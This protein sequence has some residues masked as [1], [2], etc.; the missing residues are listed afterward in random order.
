LDFFDFEP[1]K[2]RPKNFR[3]KKDPAVPTFEPEIFA[4]KKFQTVR[5]A[6]DRPDQFW[7]ACTTIVVKPA[8][9]G[10][11]S[12]FRGNLFRIFWRESS[13]RQKKSRHDAMHAKT[14]PGSRA[15]KYL[16]GRNPTSRRP[17]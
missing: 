14:E 1:E 13:Y 3:G 9:R 12:N 8:T 17:S 6:H 10:N 5:P 15:K 16:T 4:R 7:E 2:V 11:F